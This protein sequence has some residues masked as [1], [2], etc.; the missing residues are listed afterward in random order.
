MC[1]GAIL[2]S[3]IDQIVVGAREQAVARLLGRQPRTYTAEG[4][5]KQMNMKLEVIRGI[6]Q[7]E[8]E[9]VLGEY[10]WPKA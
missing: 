2:A 4:L 5:S 3:Q 9:K 10:A 1:A 7:D 8:A 6:L